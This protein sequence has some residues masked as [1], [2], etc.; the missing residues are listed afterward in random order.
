MHSLQKK[1]FLHAA[2]EKSS[3]SDICKFAEYA[4]IFPD[5]FIRENRNVAII[6]Y[7][8]EK[9]VQKQNLGR[10]KVNVSAFVL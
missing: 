3:H 2:G 8:K 10:N 1:P 4:S 5:C 9:R 7:L 6:Y